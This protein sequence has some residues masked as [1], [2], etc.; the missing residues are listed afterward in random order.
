MDIRRLI[1][2]LLALLMLS[3]P[4]LAEVG[5]ELDFEFADDEGYTGDWLELD[6]LGI[7]L[8]LPD[9]WT[10]AEPGEGEAF[11]AARE[12]GA[13]AMAIRVEAE[14]VADIGDWAEANLAGYEVDDEDIF[15][16]IYAE[17]GDG[18][19]AYRLYGDQLL[20]FDF[21]RDGE[22]SLPVDFALQIVGSANELW[23]DDFG[24]YED[25][26]EADPFAG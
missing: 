1:C 26:D 6:A 22:D 19:T 13:A 25:G 21:I 23:I 3:L 11:A 5:D 15:D 16:T 4:A 12:D 7:E 18:V 10:I 17:Q 14:G 8:C 9:G 2:A 20:A 24:F